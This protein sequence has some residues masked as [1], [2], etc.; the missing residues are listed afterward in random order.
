MDPKAYIQN[1]FR[2]RLTVSA[3]VI[4]ETGASHGPV[5][6]YLDTSGF[7]IYVDTARV[8]Y[9]HVGR[10]SDKATAVVKNAKKSKIEVSEEDLY[11]AKKS[12]GKQQ[13]VFDY[14]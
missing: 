7:G 1:G 9:V 10:L 5:P 6:F 13:V 12:T 8:P 3:G 14:F 4:T 2:K 11:K